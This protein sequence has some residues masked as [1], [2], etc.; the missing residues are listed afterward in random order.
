MENTVVQVLRWG[1]GTG[2]VLAQELFYLNAS[3]VS[4]HRLQHPSAPALYEG[5]PI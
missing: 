2:K 3:N 4:G 5:G 1:V